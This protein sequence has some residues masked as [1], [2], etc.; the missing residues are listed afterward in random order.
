[1]K[2]KSEREVAQSCLTLSNPMDCS[3]PGSSIHGISQARV[4]EWD[5]IA[6]SNIQHR[7]IQIRSLGDHFIVHA[8]ERAGA[9]KVGVNVSLIKVANWV[10]AGGAGWTI[11]I[12]SAYCRGESP[13]CK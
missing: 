6:F 12:C 1:M 3:L 2:V 13:H 7:I 11:R 4:L 5:A 9:C 8:R 10:S